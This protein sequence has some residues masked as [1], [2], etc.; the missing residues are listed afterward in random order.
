MKESDWKVFTE[1]KDKALEKYCT[2][3]LKESEKIISDNTVDVH[4]RYLDLYKLL[5]KQ[6]K[7][8]ASIFDGHS[9]SKAWL[10]LISM[11]SEGLVDKEL[12]SKLSDEMV[13]QTAPRKYDF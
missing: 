7:K 11:R 9:R 5:R 2:L 1:I 4:D 12:L 8:M 10:Q 6:D 13:E 3:A